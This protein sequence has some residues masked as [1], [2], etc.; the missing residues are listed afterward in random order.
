MPRAMLDT[1]RLVLVLRHSCQ[2]QPSQT[3]ECHAVGVPSVRTAPMGN[4]T[5]LRHHQGRRAGET[6]SRTSLLHFENLAP[7]PCTSS[8]GMAGCI[9]AAPSPSPDAK[10]PL[11]SPVPQFR[12]LMNICCH[13]DWRSCF[14]SVGFT[15]EQGEA[16][17]A[18]NR[19][20]VC[21]G[22]ACT[23]EWKQ[24]VMQMPRRFL[25]G[26]QRG[27]EPRILQILKPN[28]DNTV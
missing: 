9:A 18:H 12:G 13:S 14:H 20:K 15:H 8:C 28:S 25:L 17:D 11:A 19:K 10:L 4:R 16:R 24:P 22:R 2:Q 23:A 7:F 6:G 27:P 21:W 26:E 5:S 3:S 1:C